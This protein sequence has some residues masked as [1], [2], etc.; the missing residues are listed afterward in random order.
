MGKRA[1]T[2]CAGT[3]LG[4]FL[5][6]TAWIL[7]VPPFRGIDEFDHAY[8]AAAVADGQWLPSGEVTAAGR[9]ELLRV[10]P[11]LVRDA[12][13]ECSKLTY[14]KPA[15]CAP[16]TL[17][18]DGSVSVASAASRYNPLFYWAIGRPAQVF[19]G[20]ASLYA[21]RL[22]SALLCS[23]VLCAAAWTVTRW[24][25]TV[26]PFVGLL[27]VLTPVCMYSTAIAAPNGLEICAA[28]GLWLALFA[29]TRVAPSGVRAQ[30]IAAACFA[31]PL[32]LVR[33]LGPLWLVAIVG[34][35]VCLVGLR[36]SVGVLRDAGRTSVVAGTLV[37]GACAAGAG[38]TVWAGSMEIEEAQ[39]LS[40]PWSATWSQIPLW[41]LQSIAAFPIRNEPAPPLV[42]AAAGLALL[43]LIA[44]GTQQAR[45][46]VRA[47][48]LVCFLA[49]LGIPFVLH[50]ATYETG[51]SIWQGRYGWPLSMGVLLLCGLALEDRPSTHRLVRP[52]LLS[53]GGLW[54]V[55][56]TVS[57][58]AVARGEAQT[59]PLAGDARWI[60][61]DPWVLGLVGL[62]GV[63]VWIAAVVGWPAPEDVSPAQNGRSTPPGKDAEVMMGRWEQRATSTP[64]G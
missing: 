27:A 8:R 28:A 25:R 29:T 54:A 57:I 5:L 34:V 23:V 46:R 60:T 63:L 51:G 14:T 49:A 24:A 2:V 13:P 16:Y 1:I 62:C 33:G 40:D 55:A 30:V 3:F 10:S 56:H 43:G 44:A 58:V 31:M 36:R 37:A 20:A 61:V 15:N 21:M 9:G 53:G 6:Q 50:L 45:R 52:L 17:N 59:S 12:G 35:W 19:E 32:A 41:F 64:P 7:A 22:V 11:E 42:Y 39:G 18:G 48:I 47:A 26:W 38:W 4:S